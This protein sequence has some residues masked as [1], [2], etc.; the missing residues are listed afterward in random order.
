MWI[1]LVTKQELIISGVVLIISSILIEVDN[2][3]V[4]NESFMSNGLENSFHPTINFRA[5]NDLEQSFSY[6]DA[7]IYGPSKW[8]SLNPACAGYNQ[9]PINIETNEVKTGSAPPVTNT[10]QS[11]MFQ[12][13]FLDSL[14]PN[15]LYWNGHLGK[16][17]VFESLHFHWGNYCGG[18]S[19]HTINGHRYAAE[20]HLV[21]FNEKYRYFS[22][23]A[24]QSDGI[25][26]LAVFFEL[27][28]E[29]NNDGSNNNKFIKYLNN[30]RRKGDSFVI[31]DINGLFTIHQLMKQDLNE[32]YSYKGSL[33]TVPCSESVRWI[34]SKKTVKIYPSEIAELQKSLKADGLPL[35]DNHRPLQNI[36]G[37]NIY[38]YNYA[39]DN[40]HKFNHLL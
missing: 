32:Y 33:T 36:N 38:E 22:A 14:T 31:N 39:Y 24:S 12:L 8:S 40:G 19:E 35:L 1:S 9:S 29:A 4:Y 3:V 11:V 18:G 6:N 17:Y 25:A 23:A 27:A 2:A 21:H 28:E 15:R 34:V 37:R 13:K 10:G 30:V 20:V 26:V 7:D 5:T 16:V